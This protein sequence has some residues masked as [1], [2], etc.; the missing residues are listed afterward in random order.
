ME[1]PVT[2]EILFMEIDRCLLA[3]CQPSK[4]IIDVSEESVFRKP[5]FDMLY[6]LKSTEQNPKYHPE[7]SVWNHTMLVVDMAASV[8]SNSRDPRAFMW[9]ALLHDIGKAPTT[10]LRKGRL[11]SYDHDRVGA[12]MAM[13]FLKCFVTDDAFIDTVCGLVRWHMQ[14]LFATKKPHSAKIQEMSESTDIREIALLGLCDRFGR[15]NVDKEYES[16]SIQ[17]FVKLC[18]KVL[19]ED[20]SDV[21]ILLEQKLGDKMR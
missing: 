2:T 18:E 21:A 10:R 8:R 5:P 15:L 11:T 9:A 12:Q 7:G 20:F 4:F 3:D 16:K 13:E 19:E 14:V 6:A 17:G 1:K